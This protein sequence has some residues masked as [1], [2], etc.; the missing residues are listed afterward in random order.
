MGD[1][2]V[3]VGAGVVVKS[4]RPS[5]DS[6]S[7]TSI[8]VSDVVTVHTSSNGPLANRKARYCRPTPCEEVVDRNTWGSLNGAYL[9]VQL[10]GQ[11]GQCRTASMMTREPAA[12][13]RR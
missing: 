11:P 10:P 4:A 2:H 7:G 9:L 8:C 12:R 5:I 13:P 1:D 3:P 6:V